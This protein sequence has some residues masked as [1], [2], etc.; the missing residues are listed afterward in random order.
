MDKNHIENYIVINNIDISSLSSMQ[1]ITIIMEQVETIKE[2]KGNDKKQYVIKL[3]KGIIDTDD[4]IFVKSNNLNLIINI[5]Q[6]LESNIVTDI[7]D[8]IVL[9]VDG[10]VKINNKIKSNCCFPFKPK[11]V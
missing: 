1:L 2:L 11:N 7:I 6:L 10:V 3:L 9:C 8:T 5:N 4:N